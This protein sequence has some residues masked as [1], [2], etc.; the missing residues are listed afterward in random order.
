MR[1]VAPVPDGRAGPRGECG[2]L[3][4]GERAQATN[5]SCGC[6]SYSY[7]SPSVVGGAAGDVI[8]YADNGD[9][10]SSV[11]QAVGFSYKHVAIQYDS[12]DYITQA[13]WNGVAPVT[14]SNC[15][16]PLEDQ[17]QS[18]SLTNLSPGTQTT[19]VYAGSGVLLPSDG[20]AYCQMPSTGYN[21]A[22]FGQTG[23]GVQCANALYWY[24]GVPSQ[25]ENRNYWGQGYMEL[26][27][28]NETPYQPLERQPGERGLELLGRRE[29][30]GRP[31][32]P[33]RRGQLQLG[34][35]LELH[36]RLPHAGRGRDPVE[37]RLR[38]GPAA[39]DPLVRGR[40]VRRLL[41]RRRGR[42]SGEPG[43]QHDALQRASAGLRL[44]YL[45]DRR[46]PDLH[47]GLDR[48]Q[49]PQ[50][51]VEPQHQRRRIRVQRVQLV[52]DHTHDL[53]RRERQH[54]RVRQRPRLRELHRRSGDRTSAR[55]T[56][57]IL[58]G[59]ALQV[60][61]NSATQINAYVNV[62]GLGSGYLYVYN[63]TTGVESAGSYVTSTSSS[64]PSCSSGYTCAEYSSYC[65]A[66][67]CCSFGSWSCESD[68]CLYDTGCV[69]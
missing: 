20:N 65:A 49:R 32:L 57:V 61:Y 4:P 9:L 14:Q 50:R 45:G 11:L 68:G 15:S 33:D 38:R 59:Y 55:P 1:Q 41:D 58:D 2:L 51:A 43:R 28:N 64:G 54:Q 10:L 27:A 3:V 44:Q 16:Q 47:A 69:D 56:K 67:S 17:G 25:Q 22:G 31:V 39:G 36:R 19:S 12:Q 23:A 66:N 53:V 34:P 7:Y 21:L 48:P 8:A 35:V 62:S 13:T 42:P 60:T 6:A 5:C 46:Q 29:L 63:E 24:C 52:R 30:V 18:G 26:P 40:R 37:L